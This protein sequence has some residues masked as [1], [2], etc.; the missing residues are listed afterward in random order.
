MAQSQPAYFDYVAVGRESHLTPEQMAA[1]EA[2]ERREFPDDQMMFEL[3]M[4]RVLEQIRG[5]R[6]KL[7]DVLSSTR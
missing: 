7:S 2:L 1:I 4:L 5:G 6:L 3:H